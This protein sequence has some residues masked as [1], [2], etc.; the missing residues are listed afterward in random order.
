MPPLRCPTGFHP[1]LSFL[2]VPPSARSPAQAE[3]HD[4]PCLLDQR[5]GLI[6]DAF[7]LFPPIARPSFPFYHLKISYVLPLAP[8]YLSPYPHFIL[9][10]TPSSSLPQS[11]PLPSR[12]ILLKHKLVLVKSFPCSE[13]AMAPQC[14][15]PLTYKAVR[16]LNAAASLTPSLTLPFPNTHSLCPQLVPKLLAFS[17]THCAPACYLK[18]N[19]CLKYLS[20]PFPPSEYL[21]ILQG[22][23]QPSLC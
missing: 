4:W 23:T 20:H 12:R 14:S 17:Q 19:F 21:S 18:L 7:L 15:S 11:C 16:G 2:P 13:P 10:Y 9:P 1:N 22:P 8:S 6:P 3:S 5:P